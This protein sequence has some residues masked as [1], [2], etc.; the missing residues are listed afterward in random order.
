ML[1][2]TN[3][4]ALNMVHKRVTVNRSLMQ[5]YRVGNIITLAINRIRQTTS[6]EQCLKFASETG[7]ELAILTELGSQGQELQ[8]NVND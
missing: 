4:E 1:Q 7:K 5:D 2:E 8:V 6:K 3:A